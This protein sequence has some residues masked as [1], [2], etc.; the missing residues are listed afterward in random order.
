MQI[1]T[2]VTRKMDKIY[3]PPEPTRELEA[4]SDLEVETNSYYW[5]FQMIKPGYYS[6]NEMLDMIKIYTDAIRF[7]AEMM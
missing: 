3:I 6:Q 5:K 4:N 1:I 7:L 2:A